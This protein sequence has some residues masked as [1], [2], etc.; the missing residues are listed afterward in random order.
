MVF[1][2][3]ERLDV[4]RMVKLNIPPDTKDIMLTDSSMDMYN[5]IMKDL[6]IKKI[7]MEITEVTRQSDIFTGLSDGEL[8]QLAHICKMISY[9]AKKK[10]CNE[11]ECGTEIYVLA[12]G[13]ASVFVKGRNKKEAKVGEIGQG[14][15]F[16]EMAI[17][18]DLPRTATLIT[19]VDSKLVVIEKH[20][21]E[22][23]MNK[24]C[25][26]GKVVMKNIA[27]GLSRKLRR[28]E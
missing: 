23:L 6:E 8:S 26:L 1:R 16:G 14:E 20:E 9:P 19:D 12:E 10:I 17:I 11:G 24:N 15:I 2:G 5:L 4:I 27:L 18:E 13:N 3:V 25:H 28:S 21:L 7:G 22:N